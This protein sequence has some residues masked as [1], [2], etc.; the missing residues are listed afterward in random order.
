[1]SAPQEEEDSTTSEQ[2]SENSLTAIVSFLEQTDQT[3]RQCGT[4]SY[5]T[6]HHQSDLNIKSIYKIYEAYHNQQH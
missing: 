2:S 6:C 4:P 5:D 1:M 3:N